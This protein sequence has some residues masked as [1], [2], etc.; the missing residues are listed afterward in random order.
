MTERQMVYIASPLAGDMEKNLDFA[1]KA[2]RYAVE[3]GATPVA[4][5]LLY[6][7][8]LHDDMPDERALGTQMGLQL[9]G[10]CQ[11]LWV[12]GDRISAG[13][14][15]EIEEAQL[16]NIPRRFVSAEEMQC[17]G[18]YKKQLNNYLRSTQLAE[19]VFL[20][21]YNYGQTGGP[22]PGPERLHAEAVR[23]FLARTEAALRCEKDGHMFTETADP[24]NGTSDLYCERCGFSDHLQWT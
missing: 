20:L 4:S 21:K 10:V 6:P 7:Q 15:A 24:E 17:A 8:F 13:M 23:D 2:C 9:V 16:L 5:H 18:E 14:A 11:E 19:D 12:C 22:V 3:Q 1:R